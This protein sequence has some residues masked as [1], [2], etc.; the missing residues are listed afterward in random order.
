MKSISLFLLCLLSLAS[1]RNQVNN[2]PG[3][4]ARFDS[5]TESLGGPTDS[6]C[7]A[8]TQY[9]PIDDSGDTEGAIVD[10]VNSYT[11]SII[12]TV[13]ETDLEPGEL[14]LISVKMLT[15]TGEVF[16]LDYLSPEEYEILNNY[17]I[18]P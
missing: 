1:C 10:F 17:S 6:N 9:L 8:C 12:D 15:T 11:F 14:A 2:V 16:A 4:Y 5:C 13:H 3:P 18:H 7:E